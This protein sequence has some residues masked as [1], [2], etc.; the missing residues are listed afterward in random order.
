MYMFTEQYPLA[1]GLKE[2]L[3][4]LFCYQFH[5][6]QLYCGRQHSLFA[7]VLLSFFSSRQFK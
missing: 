1:A 6:D 4:H 3:N 2:V 7:A 5:S